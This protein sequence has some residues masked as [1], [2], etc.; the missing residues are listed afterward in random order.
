LKKQPALKRFPALLLFF[1]ASSTGQAQVAAD[2][3]VI[4]IATVTDTTN[5]ITKTQLFID[6]IDA[7]S[8]EDALKRSFLPLADFKHRNGIP[9]GMIPYAYFLKFTVSNSAD[10]AVTV[11]LFPG[12][13]YNK[14][15]L[16]SIGSR[17]SGAQ[18]PE[19][20]A[21]VGNNPGFK[22]I[23]V[24]PGER[25]S[26]L[27]YLKFVKNE[28][29]YLAT[30]FISPGFLENFKLMMQNRHIDLKIFGY[31]LSG[32][33][34]MMI[35]FMAANFM[36]SR[37][38][39][40]IYN[41][42]YSIC[43][44][45]LIFF[46]AYVPR[47]LTAFNNFFLSYF[48]FFL[49]VTGTIFYISF[50]RSFL[51]TRVKY[52]F[53][54]KFLKYG[55]AFIFLL[56]I[57]YSYLNFF[58]RGYMPQFLLE[59]IMKFIILGIGVFFI[60]LALKQRNRLLNYLAA[61][62]AAL[63]IFS[64][65]SLGMIWVDNKV[66]SLFTSPLFYYNIGIVSELI[67]FLLGLTYKNRS[68]IIERIKEQE[69]MKME[70]EKKEYESQIAIIK[71]QQEERNRISAD[72]HDDLG[73]GMTTIRLYSELAKNKLLD[74]P[75]P[76]IDKISSSAN[77]LLNKM[78]AIIWSMSS[79]ND[80]L[81]NMTAYIRSYALEYFENTGIDC[82]ISIPDDLPNIEV[83]GEIR[84]NVFLVVKEALNNILK[85]SKATL[86][87]ISLVRVPDGLT[88]YIQD[89]GI[90]IDLEHLRQFGNGLKN[91]KKRME[92]VKIE[93]SIENKNGTLIIL[94]RKIADF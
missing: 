30:H 32:I 18:K 87:T 80:S 34:L 1:F 49:L 62:N 81:G 22:K 7:L 29:A 3:D 86:V 14:I 57:V 82:H 65:I 73:A 43:M 23:T 52:P 68:E 58:T 12:A 8:P 55:E 9:A 45:L 63:V 28:T 92:D 31:V 50:T 20:I 88:L 77:E 40:F 21:D 72:M 5:F 26:I 27:V 59:N 13:L 83:I 75:I 41:A 64:A 67:F 35:L 66:N 6:S 85:H 93:F 17:L 10:T 25:V 42:V 15:I 84:R 4:N 47:T 61:G 76:E 60:I 70:A 78:N 79:S 71:A 36:L 91:M 90:G 94:H 19:Q 54:D 69:A 53:L 2:T 48:D 39:E 33:L 11:Y 24:A 16:Y 46:N 56:L 51:N 44:F 37:R 38:R 89:N 74:N